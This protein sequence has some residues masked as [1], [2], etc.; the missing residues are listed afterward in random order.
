MSIARMFFFNPENIRSSKIKLLIPKPNISHG[1]NSVH[2]R[3]TFT[4][5]KVILELAVIA[6]LQ[7]SEATNKR[8]F[9]N[10]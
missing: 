6:D 5:K 1:S 7:L 2:F 3:Y 8:H 9:S 10:T 4:V